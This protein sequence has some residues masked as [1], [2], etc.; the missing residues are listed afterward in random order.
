M[1]QN[2]DKRQQAAQKIQAR[3]RGYVVRQR[4]YSV[5]HFH[6]SQQQTFDEID[7]TQFEFDEVKYF[8]L[9]IAEK[10]CSLIIHRLLL[11]RNFNDHEH[12]W[13]VFDKSGNLNMES[14][15]VQFK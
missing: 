13:L 15:Q 5:R 8:L 10:D 1:E 6:S 3:W 4:M 11:M 9:S 14:Y 2:L 12:Q 7:L